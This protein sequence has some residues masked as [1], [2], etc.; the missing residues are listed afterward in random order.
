MP[1]TAPF[2]RRI[3]SAA[4][5]LLA[6]LSLVWGCRG[7]DP[8]ARNPPDSKNAA[9]AA[10]H[11]RVGA[12]NI[13]W[14]G[15]PDKRGG[16]GRNTPQTAEDIADYIHCSGVDLLGLEEISDDSPEG[17][18]EPSNSTLTKALA[19]LKT[20]TGQEWSQKL[21]AK[22]GSDRDQLCGVVW[23]AGRV[24]PVGEPMV[25]PV[26][27]KIGVVGEPLWKRLPYA[28]KFS[29]GAGK[30]DIAVVVLHM[31]SNRPSDSNP[32][33]DPADHRGQE[34]DELI[35]LTPKITERFDN[36]RDIVL[37]GDTNCK[38]G[39]EPALTK[40]AKAGWKDLNAADEPTWFAP[41]GKFPPA[42]FDRVL[43]PADQ[44]EFR[45]SRQVVY[46]KQYFA[47][48]GLDEN[49]FRKRFSDHSLVYIDLAVTADD[50]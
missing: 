19:I 5:L 26:P 4:P 37:M 16:P 23:N 33:A 46:R 15:R 48:R 34:A 28:M 9:P 2:R 42:P 49:G 18:A 6:A 31:K 17:S 29:A 47:K 30:T 36:E 8:A 27:E 21:F 40:F 38:A 13:E 11:L 50:D 14:L 45:A 32:K 3:V 44:P 7:S 12:W 20:K 43:V 41:G 22:R 24:S 35:A 39:A 1:P 25:I 10:D